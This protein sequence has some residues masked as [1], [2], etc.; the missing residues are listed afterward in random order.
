MQ[1]TIETI[2]F[3]C[4][5]VFMKCETPFTENSEKLLNLFKAL[6]DKNR[7]N[8]FK[9]FCR[10]SQDGT[11]EKS[12]NDV[13]GCC[14]IDLS[15]VSRHLASLKKAGVLNAKKEGKNVFYSLNAKEIAKTLRELADSIE[16]CC[17]DESSNNSKEE[18]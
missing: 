12:V 9:H 17:A 2:A 5:Y 14:D 1:I 6:G 18:S 3:P 10:S 16:N 8:I 15:V 11:N 7:L 13:K 4:N